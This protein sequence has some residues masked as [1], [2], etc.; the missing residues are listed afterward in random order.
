V[1]SRIASHLTRTITKDFAKK[2][3]VFDYGLEEVIVPEAF[4]V[5]KSTF[6]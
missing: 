4:V 1:D 2:I 5:S 3:D 6:E